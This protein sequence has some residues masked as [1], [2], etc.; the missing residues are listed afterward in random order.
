MHHICRSGGGLA[1]AVFDAMATPAVAERRMASREASLGLT[2]FTPSDEVCIPSHSAFLCSSF[3]MKSTAHWDPVMQ[4]RFPVQPAPQ[5]T[6]ALLSK[7]PAWVMATPSVRG[8]PGSAAQGR[9]AW[10][11]PSMPLPLNSASR[12]ALAA[13]LGKIRCF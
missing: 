5:G 4:V 13:V 11:E 12:A 7:A 8:Q 9:S 2:P 1:K 3:S 10:D 6:P